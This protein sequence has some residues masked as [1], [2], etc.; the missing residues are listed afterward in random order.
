MKIQP[1]PNKLKNY[2]KKFN[3]LNK[4]INENGFNICSYN[5]FTY[6]L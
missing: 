5:Y 4:T 1:Q 6:L 2:Q 3:P